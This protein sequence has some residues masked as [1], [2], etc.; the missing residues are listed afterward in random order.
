M[1]T[2]ILDRIASK[3][4]VQK[5]DEN[6]NQIG[7]NEKPSLA[8]E[9]DYKLEI[10]WRN[11]LIFLYLHCAAVYGFSLHKSQLSSIIIGWVTGLIVAFGTTLGAHRLY[12]HR[13]YK[14]NKKLQ[15]LLMYMQTMAVQ[16]SMYEWV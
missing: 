4:K 13:S 15:V 9:D 8:G 1:V 10:V 2:K 12:T 6:N 14:A 11:V 3:S 7:I 5:P 16:N